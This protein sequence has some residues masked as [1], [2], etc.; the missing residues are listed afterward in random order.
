[1]VSRATLGLDVKPSPCSRKLARE[2]SRAMRLH[3][4]VGKGNRRRCTGAG[5]RW[6]ATVRA[7]QLSAV[8]NAFGWKGMDYAQLVK[9]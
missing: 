1:M 2:D 7:T 4:Q 6:R 9:I 3:V 8:E 5:S